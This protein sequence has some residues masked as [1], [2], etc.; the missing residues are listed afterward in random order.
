MNSRLKKLLW[1][2]QMASQEVLPDDYLPDMPEV[3][4]DVSWVYR[5]TF[6]IKKVFNMLKKII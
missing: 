5:V 3:E 4:P 1:K 6:N 2:K